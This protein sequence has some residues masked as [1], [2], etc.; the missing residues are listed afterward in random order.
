MNPIGAHFSVSKGY[1][2]AFKEAVSIGAEAMQIF[3]KSPMQAKLRRITETEVQEV[4][5]FPDRR[6]IKDSKRINLIY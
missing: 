4:K 6:K 2:G 5:N 1:I 3:A